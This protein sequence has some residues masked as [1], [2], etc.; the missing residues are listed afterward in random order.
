MKL[1]TLNATLR[2]MHYVEHKQTVPG[3]DEL[4]PHLEAERLEHR[5]ALQRLEEE[6]EVALGWRSLQTQAGCKLT[7]KIVQC[8][9]QVM[10]MYM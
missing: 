1:H 7:Q 5:L 10:C 6:A 9:P 3:H 8:D 4:L 2:L